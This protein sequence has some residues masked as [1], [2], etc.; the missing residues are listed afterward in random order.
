MRME[1][2]GEC[3]TY[4]GLA[5]AMN[6]GIY[7]IP[8]MTRRQFQQ[9]ILNPIETADGMI[10]SNLLDRMLN[11]LG[12]RSDQLPV[13]QHALMRLWDLQQHG[14][15]IDIA[16]YEKIGTLS[17]CLSNHAE[18]VFNELREPQKK[19]TELV[20]RSITQVNKNRKMR[21]PRPFSELASLPGVNVTE[22][23][24]VIEAFRRQDRAFLFTS[25]GSLEPQSLIDISH[26]AL[27]RQW[28]RLTKWVEE[29]ADLEVRLGRL[30]EDAAEWYRN[31]RKDKGALYRGYKLQKIEEM[32]P[33]IEGMTREL[34]FLRASRRSERSAKIFRNGSLFLPLA[35]V[36]IVALGLARIWWLPKK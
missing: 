32:R 14:K 22:L 18:Q 5:E 16:E 1:W 24:A 17:N 26:E 4:A 6:A 8:Q 15:P 36:V 29:E 33:Q 20:F 31:E 34:D 25:E 27:I 12:G 21:R 23:K 10:S 7:L 3:S 28:A 35:I 11:D 19:I 2:L 30:K 9:V 13:L